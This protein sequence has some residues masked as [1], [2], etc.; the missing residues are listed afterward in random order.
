MSDELIVY[1]WHANVP[2]GG[3]LRLLAKLA[4]WSVAMVRDDESFEPVELSES[5]MVIGWAENGRRSDRIQQAIDRRDVAALSGLTEDL[6]AVD[7]AVERPYA[8]SAQELEEYQM[9]GLEPELLEKIENANLRAVCE[10]RSGAFDQAVEFSWA[11]ASAF[12]VLTDGVLED[13]EEGWVMDCND[14]DES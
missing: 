7:L 1:G 10:I 11:V 9:A 12:G 2:S 6:V 4:G 5:P 14:E 8:A 13:V 3:E